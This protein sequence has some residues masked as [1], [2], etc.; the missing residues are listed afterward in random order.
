MM[1][2]CKPFSK[3][4]AGKF[5]VLVAVMVSLA[6]GQELTSI[7]DL[8]NQYGVIFKTG[9]RNAASHLWASYIMQRASTMSS[10]TMKTLFH[11][12]C[13]VSG[14]PL[15]DVDR[16][17]FKVTLPKVGGGQVI[18]ISCHCCWPCICDLQDNVRIDTKTIKT[19]DGQR[20]YDVMVI[21][22]PCND[23]SK[24]QQSFVD[25]FAN[26]Q[27]TL[28]TEA[29]EL[30]CEGSKLVGAE[31]SDHGHIIIGLFFTDTEDL[32]GQAND[33]RSFAPVCAKRRK[34][35]FNSGMGLIFHKV[36]TISPI[37]VSA[38]DA[39]SYSSMEP[40]MAGL[41]S[42]APGW[43]MLGTCSALLVLIGAVTLGS[44]RL[45]RRKLPKNHQQVQEDSEQLSSV[46]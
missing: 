35:G 27:V 12:F 33:A 28:Q 45:L 16:T 29:P 44:A 14:S 9:N 34:A 36:A 18:G 39:V 3:H 37:R 21:G 41:P 13:P 19:A 46:E 30:K 10:S 11:G 1:E 38:Q 23:P 6:A 42:H 4:A 7:E 17:H 2:L 20:S 32:A 8:R 15:P 40:H 24:L 25:P 5:L 43:V 31:N 22:N 26:S